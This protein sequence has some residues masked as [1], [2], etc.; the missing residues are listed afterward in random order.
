M[1]QMVRAAVLTG[2]ADVARDVGLDPLRQL[3]AAGLPRAALTNPDMMISAPDSRDLLEI[4]G[5]VA[6]DFGLR[7]SLKRTPSMM[8]PVALI[9]REQQTVREALVTHGRYISIHSDVTTSRLEETGEV[10]ILHHKLTYAT[11][12]SCRQADEMS[13][14]QSM[15]ILRMLI[16]RDWRPLSVS[17]VYPP[18]KSLETHRR[19]FGPNIDFE[20]AFNGVVFDRSFLDRRNTSADPEMARQIERYVAGLGRSSQT[21]GLPQQVSDLV[22]TLLPGGGCT[23]DLVARQLGLSLRAL[24]RQLTS[25][26]TSFGEIVQD[27]RET[28]ATQYLEQSRKPLSDVAELL[29]FSAL[30]A[31][32]R[33]HQTHYGQSP[34]ARRD[35]A[36]PGPD[37]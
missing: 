33:W 19:V 37:A 7:L 4:C 27:V 11:P 8:G 10:A 12:G 18:P 35:A 32:S 22:T 9:V 1:V 6:E 20:Q 21:I 2:F 26:G 36:R 28:M 3:D 17:F 29:G 30:S 25:A 24:Q 16:G 31:L 34:T 15:N 13:L 5:R 23:A 14:G